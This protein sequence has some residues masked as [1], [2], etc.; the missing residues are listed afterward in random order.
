MANILKGAPAAKA[1]G[2]AVKEKISML[3]NMGTVPKLAILRVGDKPDDIYYENAASKK[4]AMFGV[5]VLKTAFP[6]SVDQERLEEEVHKLNRDETV[7]GVLV[8]KPLPGHID[9]IRI[10]ELLLPEKDVDGITPYSM[11]SVYS[12]GGGGY[13]PCTAEA[14]VELLKYYN[15]PLAG[16]SAVIIGRST[17]IGRPAAMLLLKENATVTVCHTKTLNIG[18]ITK[19]AD[20]II[21]A[22][23]KAGSLRENMTAPGQ[24]VIDVSM[25]ESA[26]GSMCGDADFERVSNVVENITPVPGGVGALTTAVLLSHTVDAALKKYM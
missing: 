16:K 6:E 25:N 12:G 21:T 7:N 18:D 19:N 23:G 26:G 9:S 8:L 14:A 22:A 13:P 20:I 5:E 4:A 17:V 10:S 1:I 24:T 3:K 2:E 11:A 15:I